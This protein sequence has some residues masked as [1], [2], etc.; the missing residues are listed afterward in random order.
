MEIYELVRL[1]VSIKI[2]DDKYPVTTK[3]LVA[4]S[5]T[6]TDGNVRL[7]DNIKFSK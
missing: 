2:R 1:Y 4:E 3:Q 7:R 5:L 6:V